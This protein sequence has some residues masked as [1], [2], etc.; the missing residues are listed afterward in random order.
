MLWFFCFFGCYGSLCL[1][2]EKLLELMDPCNTGDISFIMFCRGVE[3]F[4]LGE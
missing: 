2:V 3:T 1:Q 4:L